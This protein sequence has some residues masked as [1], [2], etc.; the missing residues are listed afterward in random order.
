MTNQ[1][2]EKLRLLRLPA[3]ANEYSRQMETPIMESLDFGARISMMVDAEWLSRQ[4]NKA[5]KLRRDATLRIPSACFADINYSP[6]RK[7]DKSNIA[8][9]SDFA[10]VKASRNIIITGSTGTGKTYLACAFGSEAC[11]LELRVKYYRTSLLL[12][13]M[14]VALG[15]GSYPKLLQKLRK[16]DLLILDDWSLTTLGAGLGQNLL[17]IVEDRYNRCS[18]I[19]AAQIPVAKW[20][21]L[22]EDSTVADAV[23]DRLVYNA[24][25]FPLEGPSMRRQERID[26][27]GGGAYE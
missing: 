18:T 21:E 5:A 22:F 10:W 14:N 4:N 26:V 24:Y 8:R 3:M 1:T 23:L 7:V 2:L 19:I 9:L 17:E 25:R 13:E 11:G 6:A 27:D 16:T 20:H 12:Q 15:D